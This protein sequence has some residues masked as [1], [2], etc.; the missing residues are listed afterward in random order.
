MGPCLVLQGMIPRR[1]SNVNNIH[2]RT[3]GVYPR[4]KV[5][6]LEA[7]AIRL[8]AKTRKQEDAKVA[9]VLVV[10]SSRSI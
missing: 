5:A 1:L 8:I 9:R 4:F 6:Q 2:G 3:D 7:Q 10:Y